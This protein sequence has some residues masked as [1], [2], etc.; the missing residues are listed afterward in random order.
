MQWN[1]KIFSNRFCV[2][3]SRHANQ[4][5]SGRLLAVLPKLTCFFVGSAESTS[6][7]TKLCNHCTAHMEPLTGFSDRTGPSQKGNWWCRQR[8]SSFC[9]KCECLQILI[10]MFIQMIFTLNAMI[11]VFL[12]FMVMFSF[13]TFYLVFPAYLFTSH[14]LGASENI[15]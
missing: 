15:G 4:V 3:R 1:W 2:K 14:C 5:D 8:A 9:A 10:V 13:Q 7:K 12:Y 6:L 11:L